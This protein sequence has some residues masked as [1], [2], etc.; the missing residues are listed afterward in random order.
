[1]ITHREGGGVDVEVGLGQKSAM[2][3]IECGQLE[4]SGM[5]DRT[6]QLT[7]CDLLHRFTL[8]PKL[9]LLP[10]G[11]DLFRLIFSSRIILSIVLVLFP[12]IIA[13]SATM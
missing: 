10:V 1:M 11:P 13:V 2:R 3:Q 5:T 9:N 12:R 4:P 8:R 6:L 7:Q